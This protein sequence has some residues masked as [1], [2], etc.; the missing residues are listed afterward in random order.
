MAALT[1]RRC[2]TVKIAADSI[3][4][5]MIR[6]SIIRLHPL[7]ALGVEGVA[8][9]VEA[10]VAGESPLG[11]Q[12]RRRVDQRPHEEVVGD[13]RKALVHVRGAGSVAAHRGGVD[14]DVAGA[15]PLHEGGAAADSDEVRGANVAELLP[16]RWPPR[17][18]R[19]RWRWRSH[20]CPGTTPVTVRYSR[21]QATSRGSSRW[22]GDQPHPSGVA[23]K[24]HVVGD[25]AGPHPN[26]VLEDVAGGRALVEDCQSAPFVVEAMPRGRPDAIR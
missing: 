6:C 13:R 23:G 9:H 7:G 2:A 16:R 18:S 24:E 19:S 17:D 21:W 22:L 1:W 3:S 11:G 12:I 15:Y 10:D 14:E 26:V 4:T 25:I 8:G 5:F 20:R